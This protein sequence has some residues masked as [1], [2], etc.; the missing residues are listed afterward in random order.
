M[1]K[2]T[3]SIL[4]CG[5]LFLTTAFT[6]NYIHPT[7]FYNKVSS[8]IKNDNCIEIKGTHYIE[9]DFKAF[10]KN[11]KLRIEFENYNF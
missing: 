9:G 1:K 8:N 4:I 11:D 7:E 10:Y 3:F 6:Q 2:I 5:V